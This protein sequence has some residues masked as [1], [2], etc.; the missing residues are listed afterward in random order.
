MD[1][2]TRKNAK[3]G[4]GEKV[5]I[6]KA[7]IRPAKKIAIAIKIIACACSLRDL[8]IGNLVWKLPANLNC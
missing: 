2:L 6:K 7:Q 4:I 1:G 8:G 5:I 3:T